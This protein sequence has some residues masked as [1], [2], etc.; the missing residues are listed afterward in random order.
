MPEAGG[1]TANRGGGADESED[2]IDILPLELVRSQ[3]IPPAPN[4]RGSAIDWL[5]EFG[6]ASWIAYG[7]SSL[8][9]ISHF[10]SPLSDHER[11]L[12]PFFRQVIEPPPGGEPADLSA[13][14]WCPAIPSEGEIAAALGNS[15]FVYLPVPGGESGKRECLFGFLTIRIE[16][17]GERK[18]T[19][20]RETKQTDLSPHDCFSLNLLVSSLLSSSV[21]DQELINF[22]PK[23]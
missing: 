6:G 23:V 15:I 14:S 19:E 7:A 4:R 21:L 22:I 2:I 18:R 3:L 13:V 12:G 10:P 11:Q 1:G 5:P 16:K 9:V 17:I 20:W 8:L